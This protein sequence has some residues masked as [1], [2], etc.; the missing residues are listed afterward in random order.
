MT[1]NNEEALTENNSI[2]K[3]NNKSNL[4]RTDKFLKN[5]NTHKE[6]QVSNIRPDCSVSPETSSLKLNIEIVGNLMINGIAP[7]GLSSKCKLKF[8]IKLYGGG[9][10]EDKSSITS[11]QHSEKSQAFLQYTLVKMT[12]QMTIVPVFTLT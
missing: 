11:S 1:N 12:L 7:V 4:N 9:I 2:L 3:N 8:R 5:D 6:K 10:C